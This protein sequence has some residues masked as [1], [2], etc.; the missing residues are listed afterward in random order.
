MVRVRFAPSPTGIPHIGNTR[1]ALFNYLFARHNSG[2]FILRIEDT[3][4]ARLVPG[5]LAKILEILKIVGIH[6]DEGPYIQSE[7]LDIYKKYALEL[8]KK[9][10]AY[11]CYCSPERLK[12]LRGH[13]YDRHCLNLPLK[14]LPF[15]IRLKVPQTGSTGWQ[16]LIQKKIVF[17]NQ[18][19]DDQV[20]LK[21]DGFPTYHLAVVIDDHLMKISHI[22]RGAEWISSTP[23]HILLFRAFGWPVPQIGHFPVILG[24]DKS[25]LSKR[26]G[27]KSVLD[28]SQEGYLPE[29]LN[30]FMAYLGWSYQDNSQILSL[31]ELIKLFDIKALHQTNA[32]FDLQ[33]LNYFNAKLIRQTSLK[34]LLQLIK[35]FLKFKLS[36]E[37]LIKIIPLIQ[38]RLIKLDEVNDLIEYFII[39]PKTNTKT[40][41]LESNL[42]VAGTKK[43]LQQ[44]SRAMDSLSDWSIA[45]LEEK[46]H[47][48]QVS[49]GLKPRPAFMTIRL[50]VTGRPATPPLFDVLSILGKN[51]VLKRLTYVQK[52]LG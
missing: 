25:K 49:L 8:V 29:A 15:V 43:Y 30:T 10:A 7:R 19:L 36:E 17:K 51:E 28:Y 11:R 45:S 34:A 1:T 12:T 21:S 13:G 39:Q 27:A 42:S 14:K 33:K 38:E 48:L 46:L 4:R 26:H 52:T 31:E 44:V 40:L 18:L 20:L 24:P 50:A 9:G 2:K 35:P 22:L 3:D 37:K 6:W 5:S 32:I 47:D 16:D 23:K 41:L